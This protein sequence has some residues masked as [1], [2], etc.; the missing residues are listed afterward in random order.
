MITGMDAVI[1]SMSDVYLICDVLFPMDFQKLESEGKQEQIE[2]CV[3]LQKM[4]KDNIQ[5]KN[6]IEHVEE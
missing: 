3:R 5:M 6:Q 4:L 1:L 2:T